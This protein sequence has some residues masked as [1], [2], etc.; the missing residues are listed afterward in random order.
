MKNTFTSDDGVALVLDE[1]EDCYT[2]YK[3]HLF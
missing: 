1:E 3:H 2:I